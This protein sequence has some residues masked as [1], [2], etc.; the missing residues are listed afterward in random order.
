MFFTRRLL[1][2][3]FAAARWEGAGG[4]PSD[5]GC[6]ATVGRPGKAHICCRAGSGQND[7]Q[8][9]DLLGRRKMSW[10]SGRAQGVSPPVEVVL[11][12]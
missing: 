7:A 11:Q 5:D 2:L 6:A 1:S 9:S 12:Y 3:R 4:L 8:E 10:L